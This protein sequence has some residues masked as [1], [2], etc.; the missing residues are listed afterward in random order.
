MRARRRKDGSYCCECD[1]C[2]ESLCDVTS[3]IFS[4]FLT[5]YEKTHNYYL[6]CENHRA[7]VEQEVHKYLNNNPGVSIDL[8]K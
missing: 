1:Y 2:W 5:D 8:D 4:I 6:F 7:I 3:K